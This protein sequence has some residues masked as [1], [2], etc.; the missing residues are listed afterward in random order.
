[1]YDTLLRWVVP[2]QPKT[3]ARSLRI[4]DEE[5]DALKAEAAT[6][7]ETITDLVRRIVRAHLEGKQP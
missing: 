2:N 5:W 3:P 1:M 4:P 7:G 6:N